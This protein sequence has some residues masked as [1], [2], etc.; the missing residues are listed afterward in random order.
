MQLAKKSV[1]TRMQPGKKHNFDT[2]A[3]RKNL[4]YD[5][6]YHVLQ[7]AGT[8]FFQLQHTRCHFFSKNNNKVHK[9]VTNFFFAKHHTL[10]R[11]GN[12]SEQSSP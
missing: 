2:H 8:F 11:H 9:K 7:W 3:S 6:N 5:L 1:M 10:Q 12:E 4:N